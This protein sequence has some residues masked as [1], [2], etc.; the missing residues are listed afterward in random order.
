M[1]RPRSSKRQLNQANDKKSVAQRLRS[2]SL[3]RLRDRRCREAELAGDEGERASGEQFGD[4]DVGYMK[5]DAPFPLSSPRGIAQRLSV[6]KSPASKQAPGPFVY[7]QAEGCPLPIARP[8][9]VS[10]W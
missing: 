10:S 3:H 5:G 6:T 9:G 1:Y 8:E 4:R 7:R 2:H